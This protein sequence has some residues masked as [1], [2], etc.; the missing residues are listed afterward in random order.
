MHCLK[1]HCDPPDRIFHKAF[2]VIRVELF[3]DLHHVAAPHVL[4]E[5][6]VLPIVLEHSVEADDVFAFERLEKATFVFD[7]LVLG[8]PQA[9]PR[10]FH[11]ELLATVDAGS[12]VDALQIT[13]VAVLD[14]LPLPVESPRIVII[15]L[16]RPEEL[17][18]LVG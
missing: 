18:N 7:Q 2:S 13:D 1:A 12:M 3:H 17:F 9:L 16:N 4:K 8:F 15:V 14:S 5:D 11:N 10:H 6:E